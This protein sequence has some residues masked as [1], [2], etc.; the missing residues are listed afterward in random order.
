MPSSIMNS[1]NSS[2]EKE[3]KWEEPGVIE[4]RTEQPISLAQP[5]LASI[6]P[7]TD[8]KP[9][10]K[11]ENL[12]TQSVSNPL[13]LGEP[14]TQKK[15]LVKLLCWTLKREGSQHTKNFDPRSSKQCATM[16]LLILFQRWWLVIS[17]AIAM[18][19][20]SWNCCVLGDHMQFSNSL[21]W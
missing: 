8:T 15:T 7:P 2:K 20:I 17:L 3:L 18:N 5:F 13:G 10:I 14:V 19:C 12:L 4:K 6:G 16:K 21:R 11:P 1:L 9:T